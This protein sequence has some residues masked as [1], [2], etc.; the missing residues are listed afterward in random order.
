M[1]MI[2]MLIAISGFRILLLLLQVVPLANV[3]V[4]NGGLKVEVIELWT[5]PHEID[6]RR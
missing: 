6:A 5:S 3:V 4:N 1:S 2:I